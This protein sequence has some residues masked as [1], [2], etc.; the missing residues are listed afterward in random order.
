MERPERELESGSLRERPAMILSPMLPKE[1]EDE[2]LF[3]EEAAVSSSSSGCESGA[4]GF[5]RSE[6][7]WIEELDI[8]ADDS[9]A[10]EEMVSWDFERD[11]VW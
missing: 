2:E 1:L 5:N 7:R 8:D 6:P 3:G 9:E 10:V 11:E 4:V